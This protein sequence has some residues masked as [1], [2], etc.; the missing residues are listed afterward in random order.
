LALVLIFLIVYQ[1]Q[2][3]AGGRMRSALGKAR[4]QA[5]RLSLGLEF[6]WWCAKTGTTAPP[7]HISISAITEAARAGGDETSRRIC[8]GRPDNS[9]MHTG[10]D[11]QNR[12]LI[13]ALSHCQMIDTNAVR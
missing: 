5:L 8:C 1:R 11:Y 6:L 9:C 2:V 3:F 13:E 7:T 12:S 4:G 10:I